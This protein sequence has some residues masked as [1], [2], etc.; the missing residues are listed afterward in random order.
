MS[1]RRTAYVSL[2][3]LFFKS[4]KEDGRLQEGGSVG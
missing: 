3:F 2:Y 4:E 1:K